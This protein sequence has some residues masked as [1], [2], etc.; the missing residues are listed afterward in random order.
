MP[1][2]Q[3]GVLLVEGVDAQSLLQ[4]LLTNDVSA[5][6]LNQ[7][8]LTGLCNPKGRLLAIF[9]LIRR[10]NGYQLV[11]PK[12]MIGGLQQRLS[13]YILRSKVTITDISDN[14]TC[15]GLIPSLN[16]ELDFL[17]TQE[18]TPYPS[19]SPRFLSI[20]SNDKITDIENKLSSEK[21]Q[22]GSEANWE[23]REIEDG[24]PMI[25]PDTKEKFT[26]QQVN[27]DLVNGVSFKKGC[28]PGQEI[29][30]RLHYLGSPSRRMFQAE[31]VTVDTANIGDEITTDN[32]D[33]A[34]HVVRF[35][36]LNNQS[37]RLL[38]SLKLTNLDSALFLN[39]TN[40]ITLLNED[41]VE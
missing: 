18:L 11:L 32:G 20:T 23:L 7:S 24:L 28:Y 37:V 22:A 19:N 4:N 39:K 25:F 12:S 29:V 1:L 34:G 26:T 9:L 5:L 21:W 31:A 3:A 2:S 13:M 17:V 10:S 6:A 40:Q 36:S 35:Q 30:A 38:L 15:L 33:I 27:L 14:T 16:E 41:I 8:H